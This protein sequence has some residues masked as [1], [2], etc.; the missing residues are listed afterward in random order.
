MRMKNILLKSSE[1]DRRRCI[2]SDW[3]KR[4]KSEGQQRGFL[5]GLRAKNIEN[6]VGGEVYSITARFFIDLPLQ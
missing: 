3:L 6:V 5:P 4:A 2:F 1:V